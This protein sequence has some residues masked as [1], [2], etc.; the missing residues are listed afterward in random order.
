MRVINPARKAAETGPDLAAAKTDL[1]TAMATK[2]EM[3]FKDLRKR[4]ALAGLT[5]GELHQAALD[6]GLQ[7]EHEPAPVRNVAPVEK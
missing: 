1:T 6:A 5:D 2:A 7:V 4:A 3:S